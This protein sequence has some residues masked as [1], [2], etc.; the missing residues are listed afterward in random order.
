MTNHQELDSVAAALLRADR[1]AVLTGAGM[2]VASGL[3][4]YRG[5]GGLYNGIETEAGMPIEEILHAYTMARNPALTWKYIAQISDA[6]RAAEPNEGHRILSS[7]DELF[8][9]YVITQNIDGFHKRAG[10]SRV[11]ELHGNLEALFCCD[12]DKKFD[13]DA[14]RTDQLPPRCFDCDGLVRPGVVLFGEMLPP[15][16]LASY[17]RELA[18][19]FNVMMTIGTTAAFPYIYEPMVAAAARGTFTVEINPD[20]TELS[21]SASVHLK[22]NAL[23]ALTELDSRMCRQ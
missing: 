3:P 8:E 12:C 17:E 21:D 10:S 1:V 22:M 5:I 9:L 15:L 23:D 6:C 20:V 4:T 16:A 19:G 2:S 13:P 14:V 11:T 18:I 7:W